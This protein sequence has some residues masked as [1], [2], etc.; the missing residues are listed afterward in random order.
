[1]PIH[2]SNSSE[3]ARRLEENPEISA[4]NHPSLKSYADYEVAKRIVPNGTGMLSFVVKGGTREQCASSEHSK[5][6][7]SDKPGGIES[8]VSCPFNTSDIFVP[9]ED[10]LEAGIVPGFVR[11]SVGIEDVDDHGQTLNW[12]YW[13]ADPDRCNDGRN[14]SA[15][16]SCVHYPDV[17]QPRAKQC[18]LRCSRLTTRIQ[19]TATDF[20]NGCR[21]VSSGPVRG[22]T[23][24]IE[25]NQEFFEI[26][27]YV[28]AGY[29]AYLSY[30]IATSNSLEDGSIDEERLGFSTGVAIQFVNGK[31]WIHFLVLMTTFGSFFGTGFS[32]KAMLVIMNVVFGLPAVMTWAA[33]GTILRRAFTSPRSATLL[34][35]GMGVSL[36]VALW[37]VIPP[38]YYSILLG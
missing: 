31:A 30:K 12:P 21:L 14:S 25:N 29:I 16:H 27:T 2:A 4:V 5:F 18:T 37:I 19:A 11:M 8:L 10:R 9:E 23:V 15:C 36:F 6:I 24:F 22:A 34:N 20:R 32:G 33:F 3:L 38:D 17:L 28:G 7:R 1:M 13:S 26:L 35:R